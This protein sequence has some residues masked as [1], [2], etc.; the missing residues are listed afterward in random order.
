M[1]K[2]PWYRMFLYV[3][4]LPTDLVGWA[5]VV[6]VLKQDEGTPRMQEI[7]RSIQEGAWAYLKRQFRTIGLILVPLVVIVF[8]TSTAIKK[9]DGS[10]ALTFAQSGIFRTV[11]FVLGCVASGLTGYIGMNVSVRANV[12][13]AQAAIGSLAGGC[14]APASGRPHDPVPHRGSA[15]L[16]QGRRPREEARP[17][18][19]ARAQ[20][21]H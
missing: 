16:P 5:L 14:R 2:R 8:I 17:Q 12:R 18:S 20:C 4:T 3:G 9:G 19:T 11:A 21:L 7:A 13:T 10:E 1:T 6:Q 15:R